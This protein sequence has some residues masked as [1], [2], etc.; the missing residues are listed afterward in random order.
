MR[1]IPRA[2][3]SNQEK[4]VMHMP[5][6]ETTK[7]MK[8]TVSTSNYAV[9]SREVEFAFLAPNAKK[10]FVAGKFNNWNTKSIPMKKGKDGT[11]RVK[12]KLSPGTYEYKYFADDAWVQ[13]IPGAAL[14]PNSFGTYNIVITVK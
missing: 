13:D 4:G 14:V 1:R 10:V 5:M 7:K 8:E 11:W 6:I 3:H 12:M 2:V 9:P